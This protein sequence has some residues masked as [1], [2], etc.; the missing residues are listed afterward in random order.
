MNRTTLEE[1]QLGTLKS[2]W[3][4]GHSPGVIA[5][6]LGVDRETVVREARRLGLPGTCPDKPPVRRGGGD[7]DPAMAK[8]PE[9][10]RSL[11]DKPTETPVRRTRQMSRRDRAYMSNPSSMLDAVPAPSG[12]STFRPRVC[13]FIEG[14]PSA[15]DDCKCGEPVPVGKSYCEP[16]EAVCVSS[17]KSLLSWYGR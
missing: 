1:E 14:A 10:G 17:S 16:H 11:A 4:V 5:S 3:A 15:N 12:V 2:M 9:K 6:K 7:R 8:L 13:Q